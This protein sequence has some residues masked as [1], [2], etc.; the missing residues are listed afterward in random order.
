[1]TTERRD[2]SPFALSIS[3]GRYIEVLKM[4]VILAID[5]S[6]HSHAALVE[7]ARQPWPNG[8]EVQILTVIHPSFPLVMDPLFIGVSAHVQ[9]AKEQRNHAPTLVESASRLIRAAAPG[10]VV[11]TKIVEGVPKD[12]IVQE[13]SEWNADLIVLGSHGY[14]RVRR[15]VLG[16]VAGAV[17]A[18][19][20]CSVQV[21]R[22]KRLLRHSESAA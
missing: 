11:T 10:I 4:K 6:R 5:G 22:A 21:V 14:G 3:E 20:P 9:Q 16:S 13:A 17:V 7:F 1:L 8:T 2:G 19:A 18:K 15:M 12:V